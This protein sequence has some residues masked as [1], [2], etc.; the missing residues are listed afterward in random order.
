MRFEFATAT[1]ILFGEGTVSQVGEITASMGKSILFVTN[2]SEVR[3]TPIIEGLSKWSLRVVPFMIAGEPTVMLVANGLELSNEYGC[4]LV[5][6]IGGGSAIDTGKAIAALTTNHGDIY[7][8]LEV[9]GKGL[10]VSNQPVPMIAIPTTAGT[11]AEVTRNAVIGV[12][13]HRVKVSLRSPLM[14]PRLAIVDPELVSGLPAEI[15]ASTGLDALT[16][17]IEPFVS[18]KANPLTDAI[19]REG[20]RYIARSLSKAYEIEDPVA[21]QEMSLASLFG[22]LALG[23]SGLGTV[24]GFASVLGGM[25][26]IPHGV[27]CARLLPCVMDTNLRALEARLPESPA[28]SRYEEVARIL[29]G[30]PEASAVD[31]IAWVQKLCTHLRVSPLSDYDISS[32]DIEEIIVKTGKA[33]STKANPIQ[34][35]PEELRNILESDL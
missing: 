32:E 33:S 12:P 11:G 8:Y 20:M 4:D 7:D 31:G 17:L 25:Y 22:G 18:L 1:R 21:R 16:Q 30:D 26:P 9:V 34:L 35:T 10:P 23:N 14:L 29:T 3:T 13:E 15:T 27:I 6:A 28:R 19:C 24:H 2:L 5:L